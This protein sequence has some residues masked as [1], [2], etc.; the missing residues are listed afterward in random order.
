MISTKGRYSIRILLDLAE[1]HT[2]NYIPMKEVAARQ[3]I[4][5]KYIERILPVLKENGLVDCVHGKGGGY[6]LTRKPEQ[7]TLWEILRL[8]EGD[9]APVACLKD[10]AAS[11]SRAAA[12]KTLPVWENYYKLTIAYFA[13]ITLADLMEQELSTPCST[14]SCGEIHPVK[15]K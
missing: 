3:G 2:G 14:V 15:A 7:Y 11:C 10:K 8:T 9:L 1:H 6:R 4:S 12:C 5:L 13:G